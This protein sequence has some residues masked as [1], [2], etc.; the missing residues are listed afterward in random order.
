MRFLIIILAFFL[1]SFSNK[2][3][4]DRIYLELS[5]NNLYEAEKLIYDVLKEN[6]YDTDAIFAKSI[7]IL[8]Y[9]EKIND[10]NLKIKKYQELIELLNSLQ[11]KLNGFYYYHYIK[12]ITLEKLG[13]INDATKEYDNCI[14]YNK[15]FIDAYISKAMLFWKLGNI[16]ESYR[17]INL[18][19]DKYKV[20]MLKAWF[21]YQM[22]DQTSIQ[23]L[24][25][26]LD[27]P[28][29]YKELLNNRNVLD[30]LYFQIMWIRHR[31]NKDDLYWIEQNKKF[32]TNDYYF[33]LSS[34]LY[35]LYTK[36]DEGATK[37]LISIISKYPDKPY[38]YFLM[39]EILKKYDVKKTKNY[40]YFLKKAVEYDLYNLD[41]KNQL[42]KE[43]N[44]E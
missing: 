21:D 24:Q 26:I 19:E 32:N 16:D 10:R 3:V 11:K 2:E 8:K 14:Y 37:K 15:K 7:L 6:P 42:K 4:K 5:K 27:N 35:D 29:L 41:F 44:N 22:N 9:S 1:F 18:V 25:Q 40:Y 13:N 34:A 12:A 33:F 28:L 38:A 43:E 31:F 20:K 36:N 30:E 39:Y 17:I 23:T